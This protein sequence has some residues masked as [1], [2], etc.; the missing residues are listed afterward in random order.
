MISKWS[1]GMFSYPIAS[2]LYTTSKPVGSTTNVSRTVSLSIVLS[3][4]QT[5]ET[6]GILCTPASSTDRYL[7]GV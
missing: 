1:V 2:G 5:V 7:I 6:W 4:K 3:E